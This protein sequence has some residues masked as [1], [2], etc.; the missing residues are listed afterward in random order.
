MG[1]RPHSH[2]RRGSHSLATARSFV[3]SRPHP[4]KPTKSHSLVPVKRHS[5]CS[6]A[7]AHTRISAEEVIRSLPTGA[8]WAAKRRPLLRSPEA[9]SL[10][11]SRGA[12][13]AGRRGAALYFIRSLPLAHSWAPAHTRTSP[14]RITRSCRLNVTRIV[15][16][17]PPTP[18]QV[19]KKSFAR[20]R[21]LIRGLPPTPA[22]AHQESLVRAAIASLTSFVGYRPHP[23]KSPPKINEKVTPPFGRWRLLPPP[24]SLRGSKQQS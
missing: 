24:R 20:Y 13:L 15:R 18:A 1:S 16:G 10:R 22:Q 11:G 14:P 4:H 2:K 5:H 6:W 8:N 17:L 21:S 7:P 19:Q 12:R 3:G 23:Q 9:G